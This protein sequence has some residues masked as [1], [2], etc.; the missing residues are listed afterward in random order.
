VV[1]FSH[2]SWLSHRQRFLRFYIA[3]SRPRLDA[4][5]P[6]VDSVNTVVEWFFAG[7]IRATGY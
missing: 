2:A 5:K 6:T 4:E 3:T 1:F 7:F